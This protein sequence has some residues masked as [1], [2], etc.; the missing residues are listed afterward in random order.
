MYIYFVALCILFSLGESSAEI[1]SEEGNLDATSTLS[2]VRLSIG[3]NL[4]ILTGTRVTI[5]CKSRGTPIPFITWRKAGKRLT[6]DERYTVRSEGQTST[7]V[8]KSV[9]LEDRGQIN[10]V[11]TNLGGADRR[12]SSITVQGE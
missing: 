12:V 10:C 9:T 2:P 7:L 1:L 11:A 8:I 3:T 6:S 4:N 5:E